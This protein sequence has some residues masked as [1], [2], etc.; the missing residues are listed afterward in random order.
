MLAKN[1]PHQRGFT[2]IELL[3]TVAVLAIGLTIVVPSFSALISGNKLSGQTQE[4]STAL[5]YA[6]SEAIR[7]NQ[8]VLFCHSNNN[9]TCTVPTASGWEGWIVQTAAIANAAPVVPAL[10]SGLFPTAPLKVTSDANLTAAGHSVRFTPQGLARMPLNNIPLSAQ[11]RICIAQKQT[12]PNIRDVQFD[13]GGRVLVVP[14]D[15]SG[16]CA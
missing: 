6:R 11:I 13:S 16:V 7:L 14:S 15:A 9:M 3:V 10:R 1:K 4:I 12:N 8:A 2:L 5:V